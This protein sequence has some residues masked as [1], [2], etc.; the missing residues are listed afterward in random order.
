MIILIIALLA[1]CLLVSIAVLL[2]VKALRASLPVLDGKQSLPGLGASVTITSDHYGIPTINAQ[3]R[4]DAFRSLGY[5]MARDRL[6]QMDLLRRKTAGRLSEIVGKATV[7]IDKN[8]RSLGYHQVAQAVVNQL[9]SEQKEILQAYTQGI[10]TFIKN[11]N[12]SPAEYLVLGCQPESWTLADS[13][14]VGL[15]MFQD[16]TADAQEDERMLTI[17]RETLPPEI[18]AFLTP[19]T[20]EYTSI[21]SGDKQSARPIQPIPVESFASFQ[22]NCRKM[23]S[24]LAPSLQDDDPVKGSNGWVISG[25]KTASHRALL[26]NDMHLALS[27]PN[28]W[29]RANLCYEDV[30]ISGLVLPGFPCVIIGSNDHI[31]WGFTNVCGDF[32]DLV[33][34][35]LHPTELNTYKTP[36]G[37]TLF[38]TTQEC[39]KV[40]N[41]PDISFDVK[42]TIWGPLAQRTLLG[43]P[44]AIHWT[45]L[46]PEAININLINIDKAKHIEESIEILHSFGGP[47]M[48]VMLAEA[49]GRIAWTLCGKIPVRKGFDGSY[50]QSWAN[51]TIGWQGY[52][53]PNDMPTLIDPPN[54]FIVTA[55]NRTLGTEYPYT[56]GHN[57]D[58]GYRSYQIHRFL[59]TMENITENEMFTLQ[60]DTTSA[61][62]EFYGSLAL[63]ILTEDI[64]KENPI[65]RHVR[66]NIEQWNGKAEL[67]SKGIAFLSTFRKMIVD[68]VIL[69]YL[70]PCL[71]AD[72]KFA[73][74]WRNFESPLRLLLTEQHPATLPNPE[75]YSN[76]KALLVDILVECAQQLKKKQARH[77]LDQLTWGQINT[78][79]IRHPLASA[80]P[81]L[82]RL[83]NMPHNSLPGCVHCIRVSA[84]AFGSTNRLVV[85]PGA[86][87]NGIL[88]MPCGQ[89]GHPLSPHYKDQHPYWAQGLSMPF[90]SSAIEHI[91]TLEPVL[92]TTAYN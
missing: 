47:P 4:T 55:N 11:I 69:S 39:I 46:D 85:S 91:L 37:W 32:L 45:A 43:K 67:H 20:D 89:S 16:L 3:S 57:F 58:N 31:A 78:M 42:S 5:I 73:F 15:N 33:Q 84:P 63:A 48:N 70:A 54:G 75:Q 40:K 90:T 71:E 49:Q 30:N 24:A 21:L 88:H 22:E 92:L 51:G 7:E 56:I 18:I 62:Y 81:V 23:S 44:V 86:H 17:M 1:C 80:I 12:T 77:T 34:L 10:N 26:A 36:H 38:T 8:M 13:I 65:L 52:I 72:A 6:F 68:K 66:K 9:P 29:Y 19:D 28:I 25:R 82:G 61:F 2:I 35:E 64:F 60:L 14:L 83:L 59:S 50:S 76:W 41:S 74:R 79:T 53:A 27:V 87:A